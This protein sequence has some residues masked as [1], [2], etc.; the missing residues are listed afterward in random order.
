MLSISQLGGCPKRIIGGVG[1][2]IRDEIAVDGHLHEWEVK[3]RLIE[4]GVS[5]RGGIRKVPLVEFEMAPGWVVPGHLDGIIMRD[6]RDYILEVKSMSSG[7]WWQ[8]VRKG[9]QVAFPKYY[10]QVQVY[11]ASR[12]VGFEDIGSEFPASLYMQLEAEKVLAESLPDRAILIG[13]NKDNANLHEEVLELDEGW[14]DVVRRRWIESQEGQQ[15]CLYAPDCSEWECRGCDLCGDQEPHVVRSIYDP[16]V[17]QAAGTFQTARE[18]VREGE[19]MMEGPKEVL[20]GVAG[21][22]PVMVGGLKVS[23][24]KRTVSKWDEGKLRKALGSLDEFRVSSESEYVRI[25]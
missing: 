12:L 4:G 8:F 19:A 17:L 6:G 3:R 9:L 15:Q 13:K 24:V 20:L 2:S 14:I 5:F 25:T 21:D 22:R 16:L 23:K 1:S 7:T 11:L 10:T 18:L